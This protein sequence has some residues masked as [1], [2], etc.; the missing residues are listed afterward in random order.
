MIEKHHYPEK[1]VRVL[2]SGKPGS[3][4]STLLFEILFNINNDSNKILIF[5]PTIHQPLYQTLINCFSS[6]FPLNIIKNIF[7]QK[8]P[9][10]ELDNTLEE[11]INDED[12]ESSDVE[13]EAY[14]NMNDLKNR[15]E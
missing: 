9:L 11:K 3:G 15:Q 8:I 14:E 1:P 12:F 4:K 7:E 2:I 5:S 13:C 10:D 6:F